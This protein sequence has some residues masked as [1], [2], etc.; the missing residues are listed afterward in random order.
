[1]RKRSLFTLIELL[2]VIAIIAIL[3]GMLLPALGNVKK[4]AQGTSCANNLKQIVTTFQ[5]YMNDF[6][7]GL[8]MSV[9][10][11]S[12]WITAINGGTFYKLNLLYLSSKEPEEAVCPARPP[13]KFRSNKNTL[14]YSHRQKANMPQSYWTETISA[15]KSD[16][17]DRFYNTRRIKSQ[18]SFLIIGDGLNSNT[19]LQQVSIGGFKNATSATN[20]STF[21][22]GAHNT[23]GNFG[24]LDGHVQGLRSA[25]DLMDFCKVDMPDTEITCSVWKKMNIWDSVTR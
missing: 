2:V 16:G 5:L 21:L 25:S 6:D 20:A 10:G 22:T 11:E 14:G 8:I 15:Y 19:N 7:D 4:T 3:A 9:Y 1:M 13:Y 17:K 23:S 12:N 18:S 24:F